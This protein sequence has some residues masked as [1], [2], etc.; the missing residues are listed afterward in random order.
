[1]ISHLS[2]HETDELMMDCGIMS[3]DP[4]SESDI[5]NL[6]VNI[7]FSLVDALSACEVF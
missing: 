6:E 5:L 3:D 1:M 7:T 4:V 2:G